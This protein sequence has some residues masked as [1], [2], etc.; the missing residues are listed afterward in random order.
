M[1]DKFATPNF[2]YI[3]ALCSKVARSVFSQ[4]VIHFSKEDSEALFCQ[5]FLLSCLV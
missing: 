3:I 4:D 2:H 1:G 5:V